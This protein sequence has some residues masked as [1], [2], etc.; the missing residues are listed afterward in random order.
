MVF[1]VALIFP[2][3]ADLWEKERRVVFWFASHLYS[4]YFWQYCKKKKKRFRFTLTQH[5]VPLISTHL[6]KLNQMQTFHMTP[7][8]PPMSDTYGETYREEEK[9]VILCLP[10]AIQMHFGSSGSH[11]AAGI[12]IERRQFLVLSCV[13]FTDQILSCCWAFISAQSSLHFICTNLG[14]WLFCEIELD[15]NYKQNC[16]RLFKCRIFFFRFWGLENCS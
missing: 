11:Q 1:S 2:L 15:N 4:V 5:S 12:L 16:S 9:R 13:A 8:P 7:T 3:R 14:N 10:N 6:S